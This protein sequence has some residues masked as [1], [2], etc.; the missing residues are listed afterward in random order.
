[1]F[2]F[3]EINWILVNLHRICNKKYPMENSGLFYPSPNTVG[4]QH[5]LKF[6]TEYQPKN[7]IIGLYSYIIPIHYFIS[8]CYCLQFRKQHLIARPYGSMR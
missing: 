3:A 6:S 8:V 4:S 7:P 2:I 1:M 5:Y